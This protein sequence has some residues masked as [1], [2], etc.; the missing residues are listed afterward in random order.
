M[1][2]K[3]EKAI[4]KQL[5]E[6][7][8]FGKKKE[9]WRIFSPYFAYFAVKIHLT[10]N[11][12]TFFGSFLK[13]IGG[14][15]FI[16]ARFKYWLVGAFFFLIGNILDYSD[17]EVARFNEEESK[18]GGFLDCILGSA[19]PNAFLFVFVAVGLYREIDNIAPLIFSLIALALLYI[20]QII[21][22]FNSRH[23]LPLLLTSERVDDLGNFAKQSSQYVLDEGMR[24]V[25]LLIAVLIDYIIIS[26]SEKDLN[27][28]ISCRLFWLGFYVMVFLI[29]TIIRFQESRKMLREVK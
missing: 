7:G 2:M 19:L 18:E 24:V 17:G 10:A 16:T 12:V 9:V 15:L 20:N 22:L 29:G 6:I 14:I 27:W 1:N 21:S 5:K 13:V 28:F 3:L 11:Q 25:W 4:I 23:N 26:V 8:Q